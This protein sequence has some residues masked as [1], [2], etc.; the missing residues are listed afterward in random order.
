M[1]FAASS[2]STAV[3][4]GLVAG[5]IGAGTSLLT[6]AL[7]GSGSVSFDSSKITSTLEDYKSAISEITTNLTSNV[8]SIASTVKSEVSDYADEYTNTAR[9]EEQSL[10]S[11]LQLIN[12]TYANQISAYSSAYS[13][14]VNDALTSLSALTDSLNKGSREET[15]KQLAA[16]EKASTELD[17][18]LRSESDASLKKFDANTQAAIR[19]YQG[20]VAAE[21]ARTEDRQLGLGDRFMGI[22]DQAMRRY[23][24]VATQSPEFVAQAVRAADALSQGALQTRMSLLEQADP[25][26]RELSMIADENAAALMSGRISAD[27]Q[28]NL[29]RTGAMKALQGGYGAGSQM[30]RNLQARDLGLTSLDLMDRGTQMYERQRQLNYNT[31]VAGTQVNPF[32][33]A[34]Q[35]QAAEGTLLGQT[36]STAESDRNQRGQAIATGSANRLSTMDNVFGTRIAAGDT[37]RGQEMTLAQNLYNSN[38]DVKRDILR[39]SLA[40]TYDIYNNNWGLASTIFNSQVGVA[41]KLYNTGIGLSSDIYN[42]SANTFGNIYSGN[43]TMAGNIYSGKVTTANNSAALEAAAETTAANISA[44]AETTA[45]STEANSTVQS[46]LVDLANTTSTANLWSSAIQSGVSLAGSYLGS[47]NWN[48][49]T[50]RS[51]G[52]GLSSTNYGNYTSNYSSGSRIV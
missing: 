31:R 26:A 43:M 19:E 7:S 42:T 23:D 52:S 33:T 32:D 28:A 10:L 44:D 41:E 24:R 30:G 4:G 47:Q 29:A 37:A 3:V 48:A 2:I 27:V 6:S 5:G 46:T 34:G 14:E 18:K 15:V 21:T 35:M 25:R 49:N 12:Q 22:A 11:R 38:L 16:F 40:N 51:F 17:S 39:T 50:N 9:G 13:E 45:A 1:A 8:S 36:L 20:T